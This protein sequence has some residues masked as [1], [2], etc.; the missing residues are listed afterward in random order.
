[1]SLYL[2]C[3]RYRSA[4]TSSSP[5]TPQILRS[6]YI[7]TRHIVSC[8]RQPDSADSDVR[9]GCAEG[10]HWD[11]IWLYQYFAFRILSYPASLVWTL[12]S[13]R[14]DC[15]YY[16]LS[17]DYFCGN[18][19]IHMWSYRTRPFRKTPTTYPEIDTT[20][21]TFNTESD[22]SLSISEQGW[23]VCK[24]VLDVDGN[25]CRTGWADI[26]YWDV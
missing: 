6:T 14:S 11:M 9:F 12:G 1:M 23:V 15:E 8:Y 20:I 7:Q 25:V 18:K 19:Q 22:R 3:H 2:T 26:I 4:S 10:W 21:C 13:I 24:Y 5:T 17:P 16:L